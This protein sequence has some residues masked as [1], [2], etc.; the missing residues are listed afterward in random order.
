MIDCVLGAAIGYTA[1]QI[2]PFLKSLRMTGYHGRIVLFVNKGAAKEAEKWGVEVL[3][4]PKVTTLPHAE[5]FLWMWDM[6]RDIGSSG[7]LCVDTRDVVFQKNPNEL[8]A[9]GFHAFLE[10]DSMTIGTCPY[11]SLWVR[12][13]Y[14]E[15]GLGRL[16]N[17]P[18]SCVG[19]FCGDRTAVALH[20]H[21]LT[22][23]LRRLQPRTKEPQDQSCHNY[24]LREAE[25]EGTIHNNENNDIYTVGYI[26]R[27][28]VVIDGSW[29][30]NK[31]GEVP[32]VIHQWD[33]HNNLSALVDELYG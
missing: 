4:C 29:I 18:I 14:G 27:E 19:S 21:R 23:E 6:I 10:D 3:A 16:K 2:R 13:G 20:M 15:V 24:I 26:P 17:F 22:K 1:E 5:R 28:T 9:E 25:F 8:P 7:I 33:R 12:L 31:A 32:I 30:I 11:N